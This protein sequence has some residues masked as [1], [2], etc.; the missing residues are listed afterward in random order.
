MKKYYMFDRRLL[1]PQGMENVRLLVSGPRKDQRN[2]PLFG[3]DK[4]WEIRIDNGYPNVLYDE[5]QK[6]YHCYYTLFTDDKDTEGSTLDERLHRPYRPRTDRIPS[7]AYARS[8]DGIH[9][10]KPSLGLVEWRGSKENN[11]LLLYAHGT[12]VMLDQHETDQQKRY[13]LVTKVDIP[14]RGAHMAVGFSPDGVHWT[15]PIP[16]PKYNPPADSHNLP[17][18]NEDEGCY[19]LLSRIWKDGIRITTISRSDDFLNWDMPQETLR[20]MGF[21]D[22]IYSMPAWY[23]EGVYLGL[24]SLIHEGDRREDDFDCVDCQLTWSADGEKF[25]FVAMGQPVLPRGK[26]RYPDGEFDNSC[27]YASPPVLGEDGRLYVYYMG[28]NGRHTNFRESALGRAVWEK[29]KFAAYV[30]VREEEDSVLTTNTMEFERPE[31]YILAEEL[32][33]GK[34]SFIEASIH[35]VWTEEPFEGFEKSRCRITREG[36][37]YRV[38]WDQKESPV[39]RGCIRLRTKNMKIWAVRGEFHLFG[40]RLWEGADPENEGQI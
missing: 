8:R 17:F 31:I 3:Q 7:L 34:D 2:N 24:A 20:G 28:G 19:M 9:W 22:Q 33:E 1:N 25:D 23:Q 35:P 27:I 5:V 40:H 14:G 4:P 10:E 15:E 11:L 36:K 32:E 16:W 38:C 26:G 37:W 39:E 12:G 18:W 13:K 30:P 6:L 21:E 29:D